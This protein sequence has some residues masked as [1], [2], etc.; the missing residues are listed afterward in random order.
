MG[1]ML[2][3][4]KSLLSVS[5]SLILSGIFLCWE[6]TKRN[7]RSVDSQRPSFS[8]FFPRRDKMRGGKVGNRRK[9]ERE[10]CR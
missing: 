6:A 4:T 1:K 2:R 7:C 9:S 3:G 8:F 10:G 5:L